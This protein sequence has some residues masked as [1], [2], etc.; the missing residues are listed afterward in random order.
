MCLLEG[1]RYVENRLQF[2]QLAVVCTGADLLRCSLLERLCKA[3]DCAVYN[4]VANKFVQ[5]WLK[6][7]NYI[8][9]CQ[10]LVRTKMNLNK[11]NS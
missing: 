3:M 8:L 9:C 5:H 11:I 1:G 2:R 4:D 7:R 10:L 6:Y